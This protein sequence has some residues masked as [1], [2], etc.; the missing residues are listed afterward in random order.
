MRDQAGGEY[1]I[2]SGV[3]ALPALPSTGAPS[4]DL[5]KTLVGRAL[6]QRAELK[7]IDATVRSFERGEDAAIAGSYPRLD[8]VGD[9]I[10]ANPNPR[11]FPPDDVWN[12]TWSAGLVLSFSV[13]APFMSAAQGDELRASAERVR[14]S[15]SGIEAQI[16]NEVLTALTDL[17]RAQAAMVAGETSVR[18]AEEAYRVR[19]DLF[20]VGR[21]TASDIIDSESELLTAKLAITQA[22]IDLSIAAEKLAYA[23]GPD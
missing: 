6:Q 15:R 11:Y 20:Q 19:T 8:A 18:A 13:D 7:S 2:G 22:R 9:V 4:P 23:V 1:R 5:A 12:A 16:V 17:R 3:P 21:A 10:Y 14:A